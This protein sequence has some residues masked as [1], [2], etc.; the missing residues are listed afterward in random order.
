MNFKKNNTNKTLL[1]GFH[2]VREA[3]LNPDRTID[4]LFLTDHSAKNFEPVLSE[5]K[6][7][8]LRRPP[9]SHVDKKKLDK[10]L[11]QGAVHQALA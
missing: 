11:P 7:K 6:A 4:Q 3:W 2:A 5:A 1:Y 9:P 10:T 8:G